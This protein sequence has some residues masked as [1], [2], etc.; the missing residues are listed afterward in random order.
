MILRALLLGCAVG[1]LAWLPIP[2]HHVLL[3]GPAVATADQVD[4]QNHP[5]PGDPGEYYITT[6]YQ[7]PAT[8]WWA[9]RA[10][11]QSDWSLGNGE[12]EVPFSLADTDDHEVL[13]R[14]VYHTCGIEPTLLVRV[15]D[16]TDASPLRGRVRPGDRLLSVAGVPLRSV[17]QVR[18]LVDKVPDGESVRLDLAHADG[19]RYRVEVE[20]VPLNGLRK[21]LGI[22]LSGH[23]D[24]T[25]L[26]QLRFKSGAYEGTSADLVLGLDLCERLLGLN[27]RH[28]RRISGSGGLA[29]D[30]AV[31]PV[32]GLRQK[33]FCAQ[34][35]GAEIFFVPA[36]D[37]SQLLGLEKRAEK[38][39]IVP[40]RSLSEAIYWLQMPKP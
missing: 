16:L 31:T 12:T 18:E 23:E 9:L 20:P 1:V 36:Q 37:A 5:R 2:H 34:K 17:G 21:G 30:G 25:S 13:R 15:L 22:L 11:V 26:P 28:G 14:V 3:P 40:V 8:A 24:D 38:P 6:V 32:R 27:L 39:L 4:V 33:F 7:R 35:A 10:L 19:K 29:L